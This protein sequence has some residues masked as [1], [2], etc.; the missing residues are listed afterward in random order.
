[1]IEKLKLEKQKLNMEKNKLT[2]KIWKL[3]YEISLHGIDVEI[4][5]IFSA[6]TQYIIKQVHCL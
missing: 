5:E 1:V 6:I 4:M 2:L 3:K